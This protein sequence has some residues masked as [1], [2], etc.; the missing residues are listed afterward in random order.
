MGALIDKLWETNFEFC[1]NVGA[2]TNELLK[3]LGSMLKEL[4]ATFSDEQ[5]KLFD[6]YCAQSGE[7]HDRLEKT[8][9]S[10]GFSLGMKMASESFDQAEK[11]I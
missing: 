8:A 11:L 9:F 1:N 2:D 7:Y 10:N 3:I 4:E 5:K 6:E